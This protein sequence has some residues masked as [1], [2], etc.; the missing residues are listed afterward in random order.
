MADDNDDNRSRDLTVS[1]PTSSAPAYP[2]SPLQNR[3]LPGRLWSRF[4]AKLNTKT[5]EANTTELRALRGYVDERGELAKAML[6][7]D[8][9]VFDYVEHRDDYLHDDHADHL[10]HLEEKDHQRQLNRLRREETMRL[11]SADTEKSAVQRAFDHKVATQ[12]NEAALAEAE[13]RAAHAQWG[14]DAFQQTL[15]Y[16]RERLDHLYKTGAVDKEIDRLIAEAL[17]DEQLGAARASI[18]MAPDAAALSGLTVIEQMLIELDQELEI[19][20]ATHASD[21]HKAALYAMRARLTAKVSE[22][23]GKTAERGA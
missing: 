10:D 22:L 15:G 17:R 2:Q 4:V 13:W 5:V 1:K 14:R 20:H 9:Q 12:S 23:R 18:A 16:R 6:R 7:T 11:L 21:D 3:G 8:R 19:A